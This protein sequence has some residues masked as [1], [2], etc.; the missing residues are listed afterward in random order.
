ML[1]STLLLVGDGVTYL[2]RRTGLVV[3]STAA[4]LAWG[5]DAGA[6]AWTQ[7]KGRREVI[8]SL[9]RQDSTHGFDASGRVVDIVD[10]R[11][12][13]LQV[14]AEYGLT[15]RVTLGVQGSARRLRT[16]NARESEPGHL[17]V[18]ARVRLMAH[19]GWVLSNQTAI[20]LPGGD[21]DPGSAQRGSPDAEYDSRLLIGRSGRVA[22]RQV[23]VDLQGGLRRR[24][25]EPPDERRIEAT[26]GVRPARGLMVM[27]QAFDV[28]SL[29]AGQG[30]YEAYRYRNLQLSV[31]YDLPAGW[32]AQAGLT[33]TESG[34][35]ALR[36]RGGLV[37]VWRRF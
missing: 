29:G 7:P 37:A 18:S 34:R 13:E 36:E 10:Y 22:G 15:D 11:K 20:R 19:R 35:N 27:A 23:F 8:V 4:G 16:R 1:L 25:G 24:D 28:D 2:A 30:V 12:T 14:F 21:G 6:A 3:L 5:A 9:H 26:L 17:E 32:A 31:V 33:A